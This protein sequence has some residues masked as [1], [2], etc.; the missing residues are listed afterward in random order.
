MLKDYTRNSQN[1]FQWAKELIPKLKLQGNETLLDIGSGD[2]KITAEIAKCLTLGRVVGIDS[3]SQMIKLAQDNFPKKNY[4]NLT[5]QVIDARK[6]L[7]QAEFD[8][9][10]CNRFE[11][12]IVA[13]TAAAKQPQRMR[14]YNY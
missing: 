5:F 13:A 7:F 3:S 1:Q 9:S 11:K 4:P 2:G 12:N 14:T 6:L 8:S 10:C